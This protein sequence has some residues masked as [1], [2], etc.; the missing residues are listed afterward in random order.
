MMRKIRFLI[1]MYDLNRY[2]VTWS[3]F[4]PWQGGKLLL[5]LVKNKNEIF[6]KGSLYK[7]SDVQKF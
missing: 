7:Q 4:C 1:S 2:V 6:M 5:V 3:K